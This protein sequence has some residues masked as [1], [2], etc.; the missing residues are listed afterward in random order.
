MSG[1]LTLTPKVRKERHF[2]RPCTSRAKEGG[3]TDASLNLFGIG[4][5]LQQLVQAKSATDAAAEGCEL[6]TGGQLTQIMTCNP[7]S[8][9][10]AVVKQFRQLGEALDVPEATQTEADES[11]K[12]AE[13]GAG[14]HLGAFGEVANMVAWKRLLDKFNV[15][16]RQGKQAADFTKLER[17][18]DQYTQAEAQYKQQK[19]DPG[20]RTQPLQDTPCHAAPNFSDS[21][22]DDDDS[23]AAEPAQ[24]RTL[25]L[26][27]ESVSTPAPSASVQ[28]PPERGRKP[29]KRRFFFQDWHDRLLLNAMLADQGVLMASGARKPSWKSITASLT[30]HGLDVNTHTLRTHLQLIV[31]TYRKEAS[32]WDTYP[33]QLPEKQKL[34][35]DYCRKLDNQETQD[36]GDQSVE[37]GIEDQDSHFHDD[38]AATNR[39]EIG[40]RVVESARPS[41]NHAT[42]LVP[43][44]AVVEISQDQDFIVTS[45]QTSEAAS[46]PIPIALTPSTTATSSSL[47]TQGESVQTAEGFST[48]IASRDCSATQPQPDDET[49]EGTEPAWKRQ[50]LELE[51]ILQRF[52]SEQSERQREEREQER[53]RFSEQQDLQRQTIQ[54]QKRALD[55]QEKA[56]SMQDRLMTL[57]IFKDE[58]RSSHWGWSVW[59]SSSFIHSCC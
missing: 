13:N 10:D 31:D 43:A 32:S 11:Q 16:I 5:Q 41:Q 1:T 59:N 53:I 24:H 38:R 17:L 4:S 55:M 20:H 22:S 21:Q 39:L 49:G 6:N 34:L 27:V 45:T 2:F 50:K 28:S 25:P 7:T 18:L 30:S 58:F 48:P 47:D 33:G 46:S 3:A 36:H 54:L 51:T 23:G 14:V 9:E 12:L 56:M 42:D 57:A 40:G 29:R 26:P 37:P 19:A 35:R 52:V 44:V 8:L 15:G